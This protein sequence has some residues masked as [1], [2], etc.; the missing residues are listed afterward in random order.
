[1]QRLLCHA[2]RGAG[3]HKRHRRRH[4]C[5]AGVLGACA[6]RLASPGANSTRLPMSARTCGKLAAGQRG[7]HLSQRS[8][9]HRRQ[10]GGAV[11]AAV[12]RR[13]RLQQPGRLV[14]GLPGLGRRGRSHAGGGGRG[15]AGGR[16]HCRAA[17]R[18]ACC[19]CCACCAGAGAV[20]PIRL[21]LRPEILKQR[22][23]GPHDGVGATCLGAPL[24]HLQG[25]ASVTGGQAAAQAALL[26]GP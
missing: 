2:T 25:R 12:G 22:E 17:A 26:A 15:G 19:A 7:Q 4:C 16:R 23:H 1:M 10:L 8:G 5:T 14:A 20:H 11:G 3:K 18:C 6:V 13:C 9:V 24:R 21:L